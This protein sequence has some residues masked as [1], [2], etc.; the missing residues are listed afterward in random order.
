MFDVLDDIFAPRL[1]TK[2]NSLDGPTFRCSG[3]YSSRANFPEHPRFH[4]RRSIPKGPR[5]VTNYPSFL[6][7][8]RISPPT[9]PMRSVHERHSIIPFVQRGDGIIFEPR[10]DTDRVENATSA[11]WFRYVETIARKSIWL[12]PITHAER[13]ARESTRAV[14]CRPSSY[15]ETIYVIMYSQLRN[16]ERTYIVVNVSI[17]K[18]QRTGELVG[19]RF[20]FFDLHVIKT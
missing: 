7:L 16:N 9:P 4:L 11:R 12:R 14:R 10:G 20:E 8:P 13:F 17:K 18:K 6:C 15:R 2:R 19:L 3:S 1:L 5:Y